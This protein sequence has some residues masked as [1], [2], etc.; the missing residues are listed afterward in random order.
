MALP[1]LPASNTPRIWIDYDGWAGPHSIQLRLPI[2]GTNLDIVDEAVAFIS[3]LLPICSEAT[4]F[5]QVRYAALGSNVTNVL[6][7]FELFG[8]ADNTPTPDQ[9][10]R[11]ISFGGRST[12]G[13]LVDFEVYG[14]VLGVTANYRTTAAESTA[15]A[16]VWAHMNGQ[17][18][19]WRT[20]SGAVPIW[21]TYA[22]NGYNAYWQK[23]LREQ[24]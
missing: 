11:Y 22:N 10:P 13:R 3:V 16:A 4:R 5:Y 18:Q 2:T 23:E 8:L 12:D 7:V 9:R 1:P 17:G 6:G 14:G 21:R 19:L 24:P 15:A 20:I